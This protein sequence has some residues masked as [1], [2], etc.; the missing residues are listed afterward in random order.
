MISREIETRRLKSRMG[1]D[2][3]AEIDHASLRQMWR[4][5]TQQA[6]NDRLSRQYGDSEFESLP[7]DPEF[8][9]GN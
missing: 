5:R 8:F 3:A 9:P 6:L 4:S 7:T 2:P 1:L